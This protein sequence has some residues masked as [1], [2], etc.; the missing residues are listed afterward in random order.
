MDK[1]SATF[2]A[3][4]L[5]F[6]YRSGIT[7]GF[8][9][10]QID[11]LCL[12]LFDLVQFKIIEP[13]APAFRALVKHD[14]LAVMRFGFHRPHFDVIVRTKHQSFLSLLID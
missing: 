10:Q 3:K 11:F 7:Q 14:H 13:D 9:V 8:D 1:L 12:A 4:Q 6:F 5:G 2:G